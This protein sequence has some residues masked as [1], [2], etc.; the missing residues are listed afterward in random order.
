MKTFFETLFQ[1][2]IMLEDAIIAIRE[3]AKDEKNFYYIRGKGFLIK[4]I[5]N[6]ELHISNI[7]NTSSL[8][9]MEEY[10]QNNHGLVVPYYNAEMKREDIF[11][12]VPK[13]PN[14]FLRTIFPFI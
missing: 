12:I 4:V 13:I 2:G 3:K 8:E 10:I 5:T 11:S 9:E 14:E 7:K 6:E 1:Q